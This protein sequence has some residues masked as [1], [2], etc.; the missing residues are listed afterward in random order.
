MGIARHSRCASVDWLTVGPI[1]PYADAVKQHFVDGRYAPATI[2][3][4]LTGIAHFVRWA[5]SKRL[6]L[7]GIDEASVT[8]FLDRHL[9]HC[10]CEG[11][12]RHGRYDHRA[13]LGHLLFVLRLQGA[14][15]SPAK[16]M[17]P[18]D[19]E[20]RRFN[21]HMDRVRGLAL[22]TR[23]QVLRT[24]GRLLRQRFGRGRVDIASIQPAYLRRFYAQQAALHR[25]P[26]SVGSVVTALRGYLRYRASLGDVVHGLNGAVSAPANWRL[27]TLPKALTAQE[28]EQLVASLGQSGRSMRRAD[29]IVRCALDLGLRSG[30]I[31]RLLLDDIDWRA[32][33]ITLRQTKG[34]REDVLP[35]PATAGEAIAAYLKGERPRTSNRA[36][37]VRHIAPRDEPVGSDLVRKAIRQ[38]YVRA[39]LPYTRSHLLR[40]TMANRLLAGGSSLKEVAD[41]L[42]HRALSTTQVYAKLDSRKLVEVA[43]P[44]P[45]SAS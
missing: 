27:M 42:R 12:V 35:L 23:T 11:L 25:N 16:S 26:G 39:G 28:V 19:E 1:A 40:H 37:F 44:W 20:L 10:R 34:L 13:A 15:E 33:T 14:I 36:V 17:T 30:E 8:E 45:G 4:Y 31:A 9:P 3:S 24:V 7:R 41:V 5:R 38:A 2:A 29:A 43:L 6:G 18:V 22:K 21:A 32:G